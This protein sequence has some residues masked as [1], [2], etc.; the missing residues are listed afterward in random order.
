MT[1]CLSERALILAPVGRD[2][3]VAASMLAEI[4]VD[5][6]IVRSLPELRDLLDAGAGFVVTTEEAL[7]TAVTRP[8]ARASGLRERL[9]G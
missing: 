4:S 2:A 8:I 3:A 9:W 7:R 1:N 5:T 6:Q